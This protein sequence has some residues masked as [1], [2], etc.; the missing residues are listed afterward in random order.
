LTYD[1]PNPKAKLFMSPSWSSM[2]KKSKIAYEHPHSNPVESIVLFEVVSEEQQT[3]VA[4]GE[5]ELGKNECRT[6]KGKGS[7]MDT[8]CWATRK[9]VDV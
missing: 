9:K 4:G 6:P 1:S 3:E 2:K 5:A 8:S 7:Q